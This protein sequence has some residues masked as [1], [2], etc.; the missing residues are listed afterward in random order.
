MGITFEKCYGCGTHNM[1]KEGELG[2]N[3]SQN[4]FYHI[5][6][7][8]NC[9]Y[10]TY[11]VIEFKDMENAESKKGICEAFEH[12]NVFAREYNKKNFKNYGK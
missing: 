11:E 7:C 3:Q 4:V 6:R 9:D 10:Y 8:Y 1:R 5:Y 2:Y 12:W